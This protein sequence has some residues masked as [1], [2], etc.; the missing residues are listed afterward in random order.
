MS[1]FE[2]EIPLLARALICGA[3]EK[4]FGST[5][6]KYTEEQGIDQAIILLVKA[7]ERGRRE[8]NE[9]CAVIADNRNTLEGCHIARKIR[10]RLEEK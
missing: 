8:E 7:L 5:G 9:G 10:T 6:F 3:R 1:D 2:K 4:Y